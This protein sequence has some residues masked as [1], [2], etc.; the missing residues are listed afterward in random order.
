MDKLVLL[1]D[2]RQH[3]GWA[4]FEEL[5]ELRLGE[6]LENLSKVQPQ[7]ETNFRRGVLTT[8]ATLTGQVDKT[9]KELTDYH[10]RRTSDERKRADRAARGADPRFWGSS[11]FR[12]TYTR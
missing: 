12:D 9:I 5:I 1:K 3:K 7:D 2:L 4:V 6:T 8:Y 10:A 11:H